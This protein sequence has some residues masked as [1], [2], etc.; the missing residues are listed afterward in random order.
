MG[1]WSTQETKGRKE[2]HNGHW[3]AQGKTWKLGR[4]VGKLAKNRNVV[5]MDGKPLVQN[6]DVRVP[7]S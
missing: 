7:N 3:V 1:W 4:H 2:C 6:V 5:V